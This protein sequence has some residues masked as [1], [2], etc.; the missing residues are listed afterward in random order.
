M[1]CYDCNNLTGRRWGNEYKQWAHGMAGI[2]SAL[3]KPLSDISQMPGY[4]GL[5]KVEFRDVHPGRFVRQALSMMMSVSGSAE[6]GDRFPV[7]RDL[8]LGGDPTPLPEGMELFMTA[9]AGPLGRLHGGPWGQPAYNA[10][11]GIWTFVLEVAVPPLAIQLILEG[12]SNRGAGVEITPFTMVPVDK[13]QSLV[14]EDMPLGFTY[15]PY[16]C[17]YRTA[18]QMRADLQGAS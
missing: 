2:L 4:P 18:G 7:I 6:L 1:L 15:S 11:S 9:C 13:V 3:P 10:D 17:D 16:H 5:G 14:V 12:G 8:V